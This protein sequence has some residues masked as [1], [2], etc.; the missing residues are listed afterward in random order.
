MTTKK[1]HLSDSTVNKS[2]E[3]PEVDNNLPT[4]LAIKDD[5]AFKPHFEITE[6]IHEI[7]FKSLLIPEWMLKILTDMNFSKPTTIQEKAI[8]AAIE[9]RD[10][11]ASSQTGSGKTAAF[12]IPV[13]IKIINDKNSACLI[14][15]PT[16]ELASQIKAV[17]HSLRGNNGIFT[18]LLV[19]GEPISNQFKQL[20]ANPRIIIATPGRLVDHLKRNTLKLDQFEILVL[21][22][23]DRMLEMGFKDAIQ[24]IVGKLP[25]ERQTLMFSATTRD[26]VVKLA[27]KYLKNPI[28]IKIG[29]P[30]DQ[31]LNI[32]QEFVYTTFSKKYQDLLAQLEQRHGSIIIFVATKHGVD[33]L[34]EQLQK[35]GKSVDVIHGD[36]RQRQREKVIKTF[37]EE[38]FE[39]LVATDVVARGI[40]IPHIMHVINYDMPQ[41]LEDYNHRIGRT[42]RAVGSQGSSLALVCL[43]GD[44]RKYDAIKMGLN[45]DE[46]EP[47]MRGPKKQNFG[48]KKEGFDRKKPSFNGNKKFFHKDKKPNQF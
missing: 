48:Y 2:K 25:A 3:L 23:F 9:G 12:A 15:A 30:K 6:S 19:G 47:D 34:A 37:R 1:L 13:I 39:I 27:H 5:A 42:G 18:A 44:K 45:S 16:R 33:K 28:E 24:Q 14:L 17:I 11:L 41:C 35:E 31:P 4:P 26:S 36:L 21:D 38:K 7:T 32:K 43:P 20:K 8:P 29:A 22:E 46:S 40:D 10:V